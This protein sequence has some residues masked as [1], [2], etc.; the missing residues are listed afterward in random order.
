MLA[1]TIAVGLAHAD[2]APPP[3][4]VAYLVVGHGEINDPDSIPAASKATSLE[5]RSTRLVERLQALNFQVERLGSELAK[6]VPAD[7]SV[8]L[9]LAPI[10]AL[11]TAE[12]AALSRYLDRGGA[13]LVA[14]DAHAAPSLG[15]IGTRLG[16]KR[17]RGRLVDDKAYLPQRG[18]KSDHRN[19]ITTQFGTHPSTDALQKSINKGLILMDSSALELVPVANVKQTVTLRSAETSWLDV[20]DNLSFDA[21]K[22]TRQ[23]WPVGVAIELPTKARVLVFGDADLFGDALV[24]DASQ[25]AKVILISGPLIVDSVRWLVGD[26]VPPAGTPIAP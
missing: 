17:A 4:R 18:D 11:R 3:R 12:W 24:R 7:A 6:N 22:E 13:L 8:V 14:L 25:Q 20:D 10:T 21:K 2:R 26:Q 16:V 9:L 23:R 19:V 15:A 5:R 1:I